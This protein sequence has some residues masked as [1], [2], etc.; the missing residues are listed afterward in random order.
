MDACYSDIEHTPMLLVKVNFA[1]CVEDIQFCSQHQF[2]SKE[3]AGNAMQVSEINRIAGAWYVGTMF[4]DP[5]NFQSF[6]FC[7]QGHFLQR[8]VCVTRCYRVRMNV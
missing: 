6:F 5:Q 1:L 4:C 2:D 7:C 8:T 3:L